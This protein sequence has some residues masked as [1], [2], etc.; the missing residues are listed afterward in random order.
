M[1]KM[2]RAIPD[3]VVYEMLCDYSSPRA[4]VAA[5][6]ADASA[7]HRMAQTGQDPPQDPALLRLHPVVS[8]VVDHVAVMRN[9]GVAGLFGDTVPIVDAAIAPWSLEGPSGRLIHGG[10]FEAWSPFE[11]RIRRAIEKWWKGSGSTARDRHGWRSAVDHII[12]SEDEPRPMML[13][14]DGP[15]PTMATEFRRFVVEWDFDRNRWYCQDAMVD[16]VLRELQGEAFLAAP[17]A[18][19]VS[20][21]QEDAGPTFTMETLERVVDT[22]REAGLVPQRVART[23][24]EAMIAEERARMSAEPRDTRIV[25]PWLNRLTGARVGIGEG[26]AADCLEV[27]GRADTPGRQEPHIPIARLR[28]LSGRLFQAMMFR[29]HMAYRLNADGEIEPTGFVMRDVEF[30]PELAAE[31]AAID[32]CWPPEAYRKMNFMSIKPLRKRGVDLWNY[33][34]G[35]PEEMHRDKRLEIEAFR[36]KVVNRAIARIKLCY[37]LRAVLRARS[38]A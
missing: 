7:Y 38:A 8:R 20:S 21:A 28:E 12:V 27:A 17:D 36:A 9:T 19:S 32:E 24:T 10:R 25:F 3:R 31:V 34:L 11:W 15:P 1:G 2:A 23:A 16:R 6:W 13:A 22:M 14:L 30:V 26:I 29:A 37:A 4:I 33:P 35:D 18:L 5:I